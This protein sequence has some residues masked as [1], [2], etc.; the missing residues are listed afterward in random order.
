MAFTLV[1]IEGSGTGAKKRRMI[2]RNRL[3]AGHVRLLHQLGIGHP[4]EEEH[5]GHAGFR[6]IREVLACGDRLDLHHLVCP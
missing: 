3:A 5:G 1:L 6:E 2:D 4:D